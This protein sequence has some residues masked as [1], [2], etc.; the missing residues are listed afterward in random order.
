MFG[1]QVDPTCRAFDFTLYFE[2][3]VLVCVPAGAFLLLLPAAV[4]SLFHKVP[5]V[6]P[7]KLLYAKLV[8]PEFP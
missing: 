4:W 3:L 1:P 7:S 2:D 6:T 8:S 5:V